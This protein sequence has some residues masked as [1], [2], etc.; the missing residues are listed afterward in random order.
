[1]ISC[2]S[3][4]A[5]SM[6]ATS[7]NVTFFCCAVSSR[8]RD[9]PKLSALF[10][11]ACIWRIMKNPER[12]QQKQRRRIQQEGD[13]VRAI[14]F[15]DVDQDLLVAQGLGQIRSRFLEDRGTEFLGG[16]AIFAF[17]FVARGGE[18]QRDFLDVAAVHLRH[19][20][21]VAG[22][23]L[24][25]RRVALRDQR[26]EQNAQHDDKQPKHDRF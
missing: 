13:P 12:H 1:M 17:H 24:T 25:G 19:K 22:F 9:L 8:A 3:S 20:L 6:P 23:F 7:L 2:S 11:P 26:P 15:L 14:D 16:L 21:A 5:S 18:V 10:P 4:F